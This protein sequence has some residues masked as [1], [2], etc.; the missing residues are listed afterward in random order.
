MQTYQVSEIYRTIAGEGYWTGMPVTLLRLQGCNLRCHFCDTD[1]S[2]D[3]KAGETMSLSQVVGEVSEM[4]RTGDIILLTGGEPT[5]QPIGPLV[6]SLC[7]FGP[8]HLETNGTMPVAD[9]VFISW[10]TVSPKPTKVPLDSDTLGRANELKW[11]VGGQVDVEALQTFLKSQGSSWRE[12]INVSLQ[13][14]SLS[15]DAT[16]IAYEACLKYGWR[17]S[18]QVHRYIGVK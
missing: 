1:Y 5:I 9:S 18:I 7:S 3:P 4:H 13:P 12:L 15:E 16:K 10:L 8:V 14:V 11:L 2:L 6:Q 17:L